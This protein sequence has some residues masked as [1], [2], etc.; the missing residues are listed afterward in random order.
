[1]K[2]YFGLVVVLWLA[3]C[4][5]FS[6]KHLVVPTPGMIPT[7]EVGDHLSLVGIKSDDFDPIERFDIIGYHRQP[8]PNR[9]IDRS[10]IFVQR[11]IGMPGEVVEIQQGVVFVNDKELDQSSFGRISSSD[12]HK[13]VVVQEEEY[14][15][16]GDNRPNSEDSRYVG[17]VKRS[18]IEGKVTNIIRK[19]DYDNGKRW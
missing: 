12:T 2:Y 7:I 17:S 1:L 10:T 5:Y 3:G 18:D 13:P 16:L 4:G 15:V 11:V 19:A 6:I 9:G 14:F 8:D